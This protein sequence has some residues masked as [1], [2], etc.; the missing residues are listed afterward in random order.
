MVGLLAGATGVL[1]VLPFVAL[2]RRYY[3]AGLE[4]WR[5]AP[6]VGALAGGLVILLALLVLDASRIHIVRSDAGLR[7]GLRAGF[8][9][10]LRHPLLWAGTWLANVVLVGVALV[11]FVFFRQAVPTDR[12]IVILAMVL[13]QQTLVVVRTGLRVAL[14]ASER[15]LVER[16][17]PS[18]RPGTIVGT[19]PQSESSVSPAAV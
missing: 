4:A 1:G 13:A 15:A 18:P 2:A 19:P 11:L 3:Q 6:L 10:V 7:T 5:L 16:L 8:G 9:I 14:L 12:G 17:R